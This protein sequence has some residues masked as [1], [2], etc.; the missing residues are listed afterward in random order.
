MIRID[1]LKLLIIAGGA[2]SGPPLGP[3][4]A[5]YY[6]NLVQFCKEFNAMTQHFYIEEGNDLE[7]PVRV[8]VFNKKSYK[9]ELGIPNLSLIFS[10][11][12]MTN[13]R[14]FLSQLYY[15]VRYFMFFFSLDFLRSSKI[16]L[17]FLSS[18]NKRFYLNKEE[19]YYEFY[20]SKRLLL[21]SLN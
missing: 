9:I 11:I 5:P 2:K 6:V 7:L 13:S 8:L 21:N 20:F 19:E 12:Y 1:C 4:L 16:V 10:N 18:F 3:V 15:L 14:I 17:G